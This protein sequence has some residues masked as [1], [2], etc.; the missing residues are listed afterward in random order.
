MTGFLFFVNFAAGAIF[1]VS[2]GH[3]AII[4]PMFSATITDENGDGSPE[5]VGLGFGHPQAPNY[6]TTLAQKSAGFAS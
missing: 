6:G 4:N 2:A 3:A 5:A 1:A